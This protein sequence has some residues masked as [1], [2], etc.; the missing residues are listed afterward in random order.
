MQHHRPFKISVLGIVLL[1][2]VAVPTPGRAQ[3]GFALRQADR[4][5]LAEARR[6]ANGV[7]DRL[8]PG[9]GHTAF[10]VLLVGD[11]AEFLVGSD[12]ADGE[13]VSL[14]RD[15]E[16]GGQV[17]T[18]P[19]RFPPTLLATFP[20]VGGMPTT[21]IGSAERTAKSSTA[22]VLTLLHEHFHQWQ[23]SQPGYYAGVSGLGLAHGDT[24]GQ[25]MLDYR[26]PY[27]SAP[28]QQAMRSLATALVRAVEA[29]PAARASAVKDVIDARD[30]LRNRLTAADY[31][32]FEFQ[33][34]QEGVA[35]YIEL[36]A[37]R[38]ATEAGEPS[39]EFRSL[40]D[41]ESYSRAANRAAL[42]LHRELDHLDLALQ[43]RV[44]FYPVG[45]AMALVLEKTRP[46]WKRAYAQRPFALA[47][48]LTAPP[49]RSRPAPSSAPEATPHE[50]RYDHLPR[51]F[52]PG[53]K[54]PR[55]ASQAGNP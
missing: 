51:S 27:D 3:T 23:F 22:W 16:Q 20:A 33:L 49:T 36:A 29:H 25:W 55:H 39:T 38:A 32:Y 19:R 28:V 6:L 9:W 15:P 46:D 40:P 2:M 21:V 5:R 47:A 12:R 50:S 44:A 35:R 4:V 41:Y 30:T 52:H 18:R 42:S 17:W 54:D 24:T 13:F 7:C 26:F 14:G 53:R 8:W 37:A 1:G 34:W 31:R 10:Q 45:A 48:L 43:R 11:S